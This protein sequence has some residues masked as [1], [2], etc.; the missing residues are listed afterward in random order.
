MRP[1][2]RRFGLLGAASTLAGCGFHPLYAPTGF[3]GAGPAST[4]LAAIYVPV[5]G[6]RSG[7]VL[8][9]ALQQRFEG[10]GT[11]VAK[12]YELITG[13][14][15]SAEGIAQARDNTSTRIRL[16]GSAAWTLRMLNLE[17]TVLT[18][19]TSRIVDGYNVLNQQ[20]FAA[21]LEN[22]AAI[23]RVASS[24]A[25]QITVQVAIFLKRRAAAQPA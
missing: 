11:G 4:E 25:D 19:G 8:R 13:L 22:E 9:Q 20:Y 24:I 17:H 1:I 16:I 21:D 12:K 5:M 10:A 2:T 18:Q 6:D 15:L 23:R 7:Q 14:A 3:A